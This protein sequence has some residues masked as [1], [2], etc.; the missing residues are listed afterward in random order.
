MQK[1]LGKALKGQERTGKQI[2]QVKADV[3]EVRSNVAATKMELQEVAH[4]V[5]DI[6]KA[7]EKQQ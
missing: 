1:V 5:K 2:A 4:T 3:A 7:V 6:Q